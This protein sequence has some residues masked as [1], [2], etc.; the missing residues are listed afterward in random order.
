MLYICHFYVWP[1]FYF[2]HVQQL[3]KMYPFADAIMNDLWAILII[4]L[5]FFCCMFSIVFVIYFP[6]YILVVWNGCTSSKIIFVAFVYIY[7]YICWAISDWFQTVV[8]ILDTFATSFPY[9]K[10]FKFQ[11]DW[12][13]ESYIIKKQS[14]KYVDLF[15]F[16]VL[17]TTWIIYRWF[18]PQKNME[19]PKEKWYII[20]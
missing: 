12:K 13:H 16:F 18:Q 3:N 20:L 10:G 2:D 11:P 15:L 17:Y 6:G 14:I 7:I 9:R 1:S 5:V 19:H 4:I 8:V